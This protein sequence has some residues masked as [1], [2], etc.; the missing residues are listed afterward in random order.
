LLAFVEQLRD[1]A[2]IQS[3][4]VNL[5]SLFS[6]SGAI[7]YCVRPTSDTVTAR[8]RNAQQVMRIAEQIGWNAELTDSDMRSGILLLQLP[9]H[10]RLLPASQLQQVFADQSV[11]LTAYD[12]G[13]IRLSLTTEPLS[14]EVFVRVEQALTAAARLAR[15]QPALIP[16]PT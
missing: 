5:C 15:Q 7:L 10:S 2:N 14:Y 1:G 12:R 11:F 9:K 6:A 13:L 8:L 16:A 4:T 3:E